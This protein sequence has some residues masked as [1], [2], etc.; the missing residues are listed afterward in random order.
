MEQFELFDFESIPFQENMTNS[1]TKVFISVSFAIKICLVLIINS[2]RDAVGQHL[3]MV[4]D[5]V[6]HY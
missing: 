5:E 4:I 3:M 1:M 2:I 6:Q